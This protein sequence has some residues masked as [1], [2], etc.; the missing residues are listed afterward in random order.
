MKNFKEINPDDLTNI[1][2]DESSPTCL[3]FKSRTHHNQNK[4]LVVGT[5]A[6]TKRNTYWHFGVNHNHYKVHRVVWY[7]C[8]GEDPKEYEIDHIDGDVDN[9]KIENLRKVTREV[10]VR[11]AKMRKDNKTGLNGI[12]LNHAGS[13]DYFYSVR[14]YDIDKIKVT[15]FSVKK[16]GLLPARARAIEFREKRLSELEESGIVYSERHGKPS[17]KGN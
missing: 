15:H 11:N 16:L 8:T 17:T 3:R 13:N 7:L 5:K 12:Y 14:I 9:N 6:N 2:Y 4:N 10:N 1:K